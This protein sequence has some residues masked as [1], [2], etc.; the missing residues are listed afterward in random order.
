ML[1]TNTI[2]IKFSKNNIVEMKEIK[3]QKR[4][5]YL[6]EQ[7]HVLEQTAEGKPAPTRTAARKI[8]SSFKNKGFSSDWIH[9]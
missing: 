7:M 5:C 9:S 6:A 2:T 3:L 1:K 8:V 4:Y